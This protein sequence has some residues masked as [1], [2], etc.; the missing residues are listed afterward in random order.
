MTDGQHSVCFYIISQTETKQDFHDSKWKGLRCFHNYLGFSRAL[1]DILHDSY[2]LDQD[3]R[4]G[5][6]RP[7]NYL[8]IWGTHGFTRL[9]WQLT[10]MRL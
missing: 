10:A 2:E 5:G 7:E 4:L 6:T 8:G 1:M 3:Q 9:F